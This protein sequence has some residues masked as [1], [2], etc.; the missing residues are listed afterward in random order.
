MEHALG[1]WLEV[2]QILET[3]T[4]QSE[5]FL[6]ASYSLRALKRDLKAEEILFNEMREELLKKHS[7]KDDDDK[8]VIKDNRYQL[9][10]NEE[11][12][13]KDILELLEQKITLQFTALPV[14]MLGNPKISMDALDKLI[15]CGI[16][17]E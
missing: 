12:F 6:K 8:P 5:L 4:P 7:K 9:G 3:L 11:A 13:K 10:D 16:I 2:L 15:D 1:N 14:S 17:L